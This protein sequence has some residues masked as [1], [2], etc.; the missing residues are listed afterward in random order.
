MCCGV[1]RSHQ[2]FGL[3]FPPF[4]CRLFCGEGFFGTRNVLTL[5]R[6][7][8]VRRCVRACVC[9]CVCVRACTCAC[10][11]R[12]CVRACLCVCVCVRACVLVCVCVIAHRRR[13]NEEVRRQQQGMDRPGVRQVPQGSGEQ[14][15]VEKTG[16]KIICGAPTTLSVQ[17]LMMMMM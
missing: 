2:C 17:G 14:G 9:V 13:T 15:K 5:E 8:C 11:C 16:C 12:V 7:A 1:H 4:L 6:G 3:D 10:V